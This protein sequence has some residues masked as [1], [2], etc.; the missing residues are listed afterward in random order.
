MPSFIW[1]EPRLAH[2]VSPKLVGDDT[3]GGQPV[4]VVAFYMALGD[5]PS[6]TY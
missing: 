3:V 5:S 1:D 4:H 2:M 6:G